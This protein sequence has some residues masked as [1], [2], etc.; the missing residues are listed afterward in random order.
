VENAGENLTV[1]SSLVKVLR[2]SRTGCPG[3]DFV[4]STN[5]LPAS[6]IL[7]SRILSTGMPSLVTT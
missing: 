5:V 2:V 6:S 1:Y 3:T 4:I 7:I